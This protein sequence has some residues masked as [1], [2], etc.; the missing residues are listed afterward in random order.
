MTVALIARSSSPPEMPAAESEKQASDET[1]GG[2]SR[3]TLTSMNFLNYNFAAEQGALPN[4]GKK[5]FPIL[6]DPLKTG[7]PAG[8]P[9]E[10]PHCTPGS[11]CRATI[12]YLT[13]LLHRRRPSPENVAHGVQGFL[14][15]VHGDCSWPTLALNL[16]DRPARRSG[17]K[18]RSIIMNWIHLWTDKML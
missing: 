10:P 8:P 11:S 1:A 6:S 4:S 17:T 2:I 3:P 5:L 9:S 13:Q 15:F 12:S 16:S 18:P 7:Q 14:C